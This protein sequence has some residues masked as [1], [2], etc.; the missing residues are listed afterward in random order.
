MNDARIPIPPPFARLDDVAAG[1][2]ALER[3]LLARNDRR[4][5]FATAYLT[6]AQTLDAWLANERFVQNGAVSACAIVFANA[7]RSA[8]ASYDEGNHDAVP[9]AWRLAFGACADTRTSAVRL[10]V[11]G[12][13][14]H[15]NHDLPFAIL[16]SGLDLNCP[17]CAGDY[18]LV[19]A[20]LGDAARVARGRVAALY[21]RRLHLANFLFGTAIDYAVARSLQSA[22]LNAW[23]LAQTLR[24]ARSGPTRAA[25]AAFIETRA[26]RAAELILSSDAPADWLRRLSGTLA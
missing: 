24:A 16:D 22:R 13:N 18:A 11:L 4:S 3:A 19:N 8:I 1:L 20:A 9:A 21:R 26:A 23:A 12:I 15:V 7:Y 17:A 6:S 14:A 5:V 2:A 25:V 10:L